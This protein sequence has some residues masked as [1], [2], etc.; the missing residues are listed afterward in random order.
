MALRN[1]ASTGG[2]SRRGA[3]FRPSGGLSLNSA[4]SS[5]SSKRSG[6]WARTKPGGLP[7]SPGASMRDTDGIH[8]PTR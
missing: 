2:N 1:C 7:A 6:P 8:H 3:E 4:V 5:Q